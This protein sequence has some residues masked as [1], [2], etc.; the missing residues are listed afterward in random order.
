[1]NLA[2]CNYKQ[3]RSATAWLYFSEAAGQAKSAGQIE[4]E[5][6]ARRRASDLE[7]SVV[8]L[9]LLVPVVSRV[10]GMRV[11][12]DGID[13]DSEVLGVGVPVDPGVHVI[14]ASAPGLLLVHA[15]E[16]GPCRRRKRLCPL[17]S[18]LW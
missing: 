4:R 7:A 14:E 3:K 15:S 17:S 16:C 10:F 6:F 1:M 9:S 5:D 18:A 11:T 8:R 2:E 13:V 12:R